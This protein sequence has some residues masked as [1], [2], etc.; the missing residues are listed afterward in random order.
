MTEAVGDWQP[1]FEANAPALVLFAR[2][3]T[4]S[5]ADAED[6]VQDAFVRFWR[7]GRHRAEDPKAYLFSCVKRA[8][9]DHR[10]GRLRRDRREGQAAAARRE[11]EPLFAS[12]LERDEW[13]QGVEAAVARLPAPQREVLVLKIWAGLTF[14]QIAAVVEVGPNTAASRYRYALEALRRQL[15]E[16]AVP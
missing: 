4:A 10:R 15:A 3:W 6:V 13:R 5:H 16:E 8:A 1:W 7:D 12:D 11:S 2:Q 14:P 9:L